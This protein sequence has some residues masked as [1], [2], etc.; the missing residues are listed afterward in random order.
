ME[1]PTAAEHAPVSLQTEMS[2]G[3]VI[4]GCV[5]WAEAASEASSATT[6]TAHREVISNAAW[7]PPT[8][9]KPVGIFINSNANWP[10]AG[11]LAREAPYHG[12]TSWLL[13]PQIV[14]AVIRELKFAD[15]PSTGTFNLLHFTNF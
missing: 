6:Q 5:C 14:A 1:K 13:V 8:E 15:V 12:R 10:L 3:Q 2:A 7:Q 11:K 9:R 4:I